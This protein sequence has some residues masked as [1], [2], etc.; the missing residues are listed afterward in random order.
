ME[1]QKKSNGQ[2]LA[3]E[4]EP[5]KSEDA[6]SKI[7]TSEPK[8]T[9]KKSR[10]K[11]KASY[12]QQKKSIVKYLATKDRV[13]VWLEPEEKTELKRM[14]EAEGVS[15]SDYIRK[16]VLMDKRPCPKKKEEA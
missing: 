5:E 8:I 10:K 9:E 2:A 6:I 13:T 7:E 12:Q 4:L 1:E 3:E 16:R 15:L 11:P 14:A